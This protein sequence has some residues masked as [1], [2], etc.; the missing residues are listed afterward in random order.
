MFRLP[1]QLGITL[2]LVSFSFGSAH[3]LLPRISYQQQ[4]SV[5]IKGSVPDPSGEYP[6]VNVIFVAEE[7][8]SVRSTRSNICK[9][10]AIKFELPLNDPFNCAVDVS[11]AVREARGLAMQ[12]PAVYSD[13]IR[14]LESGLLD[15]GIHAHNLPQTNVYNQPTVASF[16]R[17]RIKDLSGGSNSLSPLSACEVGFGAGHS[18]LL[19]LVETIEQNPPGLVYSFEVLDA[20]FTVPAHDLVDL[21]FP[22]RLKLLL[23]DGPDVI[24]QLPHY[25]P[26]ARCNIL[27]LSGTS[28][29]NDT[30][31]QISFFSPLVAENHLLILPFT[32]NLDSNPAF[33][34]WKDAEAQ[35]SLEWEGTSNGDGGFVFGNLNVV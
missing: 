4:L 15:S 34:A 21:A 32:N 27:I 11:N 23:G 19:F 33:Q 20:L 7:G 16:L 30:M 26:E 10:V 6:P 9:Q 24:S 12:H 3:I 22:D 17:M 5:P 31:A 35:G 18:A 1:P 13:A 8:H 28:T 25:Y 14:S 2:L 29:Y